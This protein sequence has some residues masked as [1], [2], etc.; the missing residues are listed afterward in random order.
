MSS[1]ALGPDL[2]P[3]RVVRTLGA[4]GMG[5]VL[6]AE[7]T[8][9][10]RQVALKR[11]SGPEAETPFGRQQMMREARA[12]ANLSHPHIAAVHDV[13]DVDGRLVIVFEYVEGETL[14]ARIARGPLPVADALEIA[15]QLADALD[16]AHARGI[17]HRDL[18]P[19]NVILTKEG[20]A[21]VLDFGI[22]RSLHRDPATAS[23]FGTT[24]PGALIGTPGYAAP[25]QWL[26]QPVDGRTDLYGLGVVLFEMITGRRPF[27]GTNAIGLASAM[28]QSDAPLLSSVTA[29]LVPELDKLI[30]SA[31]ARDPADRPMS[32]RAFESAIERLQARLGGGQVEELPTEKPMASPPR[33]AIR[34]TVRRWGPAA[35][36]LLIGILVGLGTLLPRRNPAPPPAPTAAQPARPPV[37]AILPLTNASGD[38]DKDYLAAGVAESLVTSL[39]SLPSITVLS[40]RSVVDARTRQVDTAG[41]ARDLDATYL[42]DGSVQ[43]SG[44]RL[45]IALTLLRPDGSVAWGES[46]EG[47]AGSIFD[48]QARL[49]AALSGALQVRLSAEERSRLEQ[50][51][52]S[53]P[54]AL[55]AY[56]QGQALLERRDMRGNVDA[57]IAA[58]SRA[59]TL[60]PRYALAYAALGEAYWTRWSFTRD[61]TDV[62][63][64]IDA[65]TS[66]LRLDGDR[67]EVRYALAI[68]LAG[69]G[70]RAEA[71]E[72]LQRA[73]AL[74]PNYDDARRQLGRVLEQ[75]GKIEESA[76]EFRKAIALRPNAWVAYSDM[77]NMLYR[78]ARYD[79]A[80]E[81]FQR[82]ADL[83]PD[84]PFG[85]QQLGTVYHQL[86][87]NARALSYYTQAIAR[88]ATPE[89]YSNIGAI[90]HQRGAYGEAVEAYQQAIALRPTSH[91][92][93]RN[94]GD[95]YRR[96]GRE[97]DAQDAYR[98]A[99][100]LVEAQVR[101]NPNDARSLA[102]LAVYTAK[103]G[104][105][106]AAR[107]RLRQ[108][109]ALSPTDV[110]VL[111]RAAVVHALG[112]RPEAALE[113]L[114]QAI[115]RGYSRA[116]AEI[117]EDFE[118]LRTL[119]G[120][121]ALIAQRTPGD[122][123]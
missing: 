58:F 92:T 111:Y 101:V 112:G 10:G 121:Q 52:T 40:R 61:Q 120:Y 60:D 30:A 49:A 7:D 17:V 22:A 123:Q 12:A 67:A 55:Q 35:A 20:Q 9:L 73:L 46:V 114:Q 14:S 4:G 11:L 8:R 62:D 109:L 106:A 2:G 88:Q 107:G 113:A 36:L 97:R 105:D 68:T 70:K 54:E 103:L 41:L 66:A 76:A 102:A 71:I 16:A 89:A 116:V 29:D 34:A 69:S 51:P 119:P 3:Y 32:A 94:L 59:V 78:A 122:R 23:H 82:V 26:G 43:Q 42:V 47:L 104:E 38:A 50:A 64:A 72:E 31:L 98:R 117:D 65:G 80:I 5:T 39:A 85:F 115:E 90:H 87:D 25:E 28:L 95:A 93:H 118:S 1:A 48:L 21:K 6:L 96:L 83:R 45:R 56:W 27:A 99:V 91:I 86:G 33:T 44:D 77:G 100:Q 19:S 63:R 81:M 74:R 108:A 15:R 75:Q 53:V 79:E 24:V 13:L 37:V 110:Q 57:A 18:K 84:S